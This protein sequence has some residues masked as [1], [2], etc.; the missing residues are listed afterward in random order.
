MGDK[1]DIFALGVMLFIS[2]F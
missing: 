1:L 2:L